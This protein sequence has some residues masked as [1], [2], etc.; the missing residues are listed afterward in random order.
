VSEVDPAAQDGKKLS[1]DD[2]IEIKRL[3][4]TGETQ[5][6]IA[7]SYGLSTTAIGQIARGETWKRASP[8]SVGRRGVVNEQVAKR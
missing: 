2:V 5:G 6:R 4:A 8:R 3:L 1:L 7:G